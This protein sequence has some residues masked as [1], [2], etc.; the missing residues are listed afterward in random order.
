MPN[1]KYVAK[2]CAVYFVPTQ[3]P[4]WVL[5]PAQVDYQNIFASN[6]AATFY[7]RS[8]TFESIIETVDVTGIGQGIISNAD[9]KF[10]VR[11]TMNKLIPISALGLSNYKVVPKDADLTIRFYNAPSFRSNLT[12]YNDLIM[13]G[14]AR[15]LN[16]TFSVENVRVD[17][18]GDSFVYRRPTRVNGRGRIEGL[19]PLRTV[20]N[21]ENFIFLLNDINN[22][23]VVGITA[24]IPMATNT[25]TFSFTAGVTRTNVNIDNPVRQDLELASIG[26]YPLTD[27]T[28]TVEYRDSAFELFRMVS[29]LYT[30]LSFGVGIALS[31][32]W[33]SL[34]TSRRF[35]GFFG[36]EEL[37][38]NI[39]EG[40]VTMDITGVLHNTGVISGQPIDIY[41]DAV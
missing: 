31:G 33:G 30:H 8:L 20:A 35:A 24:V 5:T 1:N 13:E 32:G 23:R 21:D 11:V 22:K 12:T 4:N 38:L 40:D 29:G 26:F 17:G 14:Y 39:S 16:L 15:S 3:N 18:F 27:Y 36:V 2:D 19:V 7:A 34:S 9:G 25:C 37:T 28:S 6:N 41:T 10:D